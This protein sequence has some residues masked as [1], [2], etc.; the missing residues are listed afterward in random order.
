MNLRR[1]LAL[2]LAVTSFTLN[3]HQGELGTI[4]GDKMT[5]FWADHAISGHVGNQ[6]V[7]AVT[8]VGEFKLHHW[9]HAE[10]FVTTLEASE[11]GMGGEI[12]SHKE[13]GSATTTTVKI[14][15][16]DRK[17]VFS[18]TLDG[19]PFTLAVASKTMNGHHYVAPEFKLTVGT[20][21]YPFKM[22][23]GQAC[24]GCIGKIAFVVVGMLRS[25]GVL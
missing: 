17:G 22:A 16:F 19:E 23:D 20:K 18:G 25:S 7:Y 4:T 6:P 5:V 15:G 2:A 13:D 10:N 12:A 21:V 24:P 9:A 14:T 8:E 11:S 3:A 1:F